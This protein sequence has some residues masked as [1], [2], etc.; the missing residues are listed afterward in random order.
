MKSNKLETKNILYILVTCTK[1]PTRFK[2]LKNTVNSI[3]ETFPENILNDDFL[4]FD[5]GST[6]AGHEEYLKSKFKNVFRT[7]DNV[8]LFSG[9]NWVVNNYESHL[10]KKFDYML[11]ISSDSIMYD[12]HKLN[13]VEPYFEKHPQVGCVRTEEFIYEKRHLFDKEQN[14][15]ETFYRSRCFQKNMYTHKRAVYSK[16]EFDNVL[17]C[18]LHPVI[19]GVNR[20]DAYKKVFNKL[21]EQTHMSEGDYMREYNALYEACGVVDGGVWYA[22]NHEPS[23]RG[24]AING[25]WLTEEE[26]EKMDYHN[27]RNKNPIYLKPNVV[28]IS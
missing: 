8:G 7:V 25:S 9:L 6:V 15:K 18:N 1:E 19:H 20:I 28:K 26:S 16:T 5:N 10:H 4:V 12:L 2:L 3:L 14:H 21:S 27:T 23:L 13:E 22:P 11:F 24:E 17:T